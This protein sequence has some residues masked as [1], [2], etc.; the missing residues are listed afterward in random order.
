MAKNILKNP[1]F[2]LGSAVLIGASITTFVVV[3]YKR[4]KRD[5]KTIMDIIELGEN[6]T[7][8]YSDLTYSSAF[9][10]NVWRDGCGVEFSGNRIVNKGKLSYNSIEEV[11]DDAKIIYDAKAGLNPL[12]FLD[13]TDRD[14]EN[15]VIGV[16][17]KLRSKCDVS[18]LSAVFWQ[19]YKRDLYSYLRFVDKGDNKET[20]YNIIKKL[21]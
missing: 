11:Y 14:N 7:G 20:L 18:A 1:Y 4:K 5:I 8:T 16:F 15:A 6:E 10:R 9:D 3:S 2:Y 17:R 12:K 19:K 13:A 21:A